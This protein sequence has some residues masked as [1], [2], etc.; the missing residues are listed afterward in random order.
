[1]K[2]IKIDEVPNKINKI[3]EDVNKS[4]AILIVNKNKINNCYLVDE[5]YF[6]SLL[7]T[8]EI[9]SSKELTKSILSEGETRYE[10][11]ISCDELEW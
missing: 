3:F 1:M 6:N 4:G 11:A 10:D 7:S 5:E 2:K 8:I 9:E